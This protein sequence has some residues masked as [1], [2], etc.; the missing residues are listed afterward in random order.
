LQKHKRYVHSNSRPCHCP[1][2]RKT[3]KTDGHLNCHVRIHTCAKLYSCKHCSEC[4][5]RRHQLKTHLLKSHNEG[6][7]FVC[8]ICQ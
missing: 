1:Q 8:R 4:F 2:C 3:F 6:T 7:G 5:A